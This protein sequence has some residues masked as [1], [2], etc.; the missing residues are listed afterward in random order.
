[1][2]FH[3]AVAEASR[4][5]LIPVCNQVVRSRTVPHLQQNPAFTEHQGTD[6]PLAA[7]PRGG[8]RRHPRRGR[9][10]GRD[11]SRRSLQHY[12]A[13]YVPEEDRQPLLAL[14]A[15]DEPEHH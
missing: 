1:M 11:H 15:A 2:A 10:W 6:A 4:N 14:P 7:P 12:Y 3:D 9:S 13:V 5:A 8:S